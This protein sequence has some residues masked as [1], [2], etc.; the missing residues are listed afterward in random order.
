MS[1]QCSFQ[2]TSERKKGSFPLK[3]HRKAVPQQQAAA[4]ANGHLLQQM[5]SEYLFPL[6]IIVPIGYIVYHSCFK[7]HSIQSQFINILSFRSQRRTSHC[8][9]NECKPGIFCK[10]GILSKKSWGKLGAYSISM[11]FLK[12]DVVLAV[13]H[14]KG[15][16]KLT[17][18]YIQI[19][20]ILPK[21]ST[22]FKLAEF[23]VINLQ[24][25][26]MLVALY[27]NM[28]SVFQDSISIKIKV[29]PPNITLSQDYTND[30]C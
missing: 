11:L 1:E 24:D 3:L 15:K 23:P 30:K 2:K 29:P 22:E 5:V 14:N 8:R 17:Q 25:L 21:M 27:R 26:S 12:L 6:G 19:H 10:P 13:V 28:K 20:T 18:Y 7:S 16:E 9:L 4:A